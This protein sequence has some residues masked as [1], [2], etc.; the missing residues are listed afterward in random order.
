MRL[1]QHCERSFERMSFHSRLAANC[2]SSVVG[3]R[4]KSSLGD[5]EKIIRT[6]EEISDRV[7]NK[8]VIHIAS[9]AMAPHPNIPSKAP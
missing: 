8:V 3:H 1:A 4:Q 9:V 6:I 2:S 5:A 7:M